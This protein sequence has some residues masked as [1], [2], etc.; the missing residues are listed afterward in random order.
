MNCQTS[1][2][3][4]RTMALPVLAR[5][6]QCR[7]F[8]ECHPPTSFVVS[9]RDARRQV[10]VY[11]EHIRAPARISERECNHHLAAHRG[12]GRLEL[13]YFEETGRRNFE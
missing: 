6:D 2:N 11:G 10:V 5:L 8:I 9:W 7:K 12:I 13:H 1:P 3:S 4:W